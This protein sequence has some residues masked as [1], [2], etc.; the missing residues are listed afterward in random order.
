MFGS[1][2]FARRPR[3]FDYTPRHYDAEKEAREARRRELLGEDAYTEEEIKAMKPGQYLRENIRARRGQVL[4]QNK[5]RRQ[6]NRRRG[7]I[8]LVIVVIVYFWLLR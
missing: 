8:L 2:V 1:K 6:R 7:M 5:E 3:Q 4:R